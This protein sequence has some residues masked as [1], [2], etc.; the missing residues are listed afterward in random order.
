MDAATLATF[1]SQLQ[2]RQTELLAQIAAQ[3]GG[4][5]G[6]AEAAA[7]HFGHPED[8]PAQVNTERDTDFALG[9]HE[10]AHLNAIGQALQRIAEGSYGQCTDCGITILAARLH[11][12]PEAARCISCQEVAEHS[13]PH[14]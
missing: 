5:I 7:A 9:E 4:E 14:R 11:A 3:R 6:R 10:V 2:A 1:R 12:N 13:G 8:T